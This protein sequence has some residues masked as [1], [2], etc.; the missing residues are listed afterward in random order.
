VLLK[1]LGSDFPAAGSSSFNKYGLGTCEADHFRVTDPVRRG[2]NHLV[3]FFTD[4]EDRIEAGLFG[5]AVD[6]DL[7]G[8]VIDPVIGFKFIGNSFAELGDAGGG[9]VLGF[10]RIQGLDGSLFDEV[11]CVLIRFSTGKSVDLFA[12]GFE[13]L[14]LVGDRKGEGR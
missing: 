6:D 13:G 1:L 4:G 3:T 11:G 8:I 2:D 10:P 9:S 14:G 12:L 7:A 5:S